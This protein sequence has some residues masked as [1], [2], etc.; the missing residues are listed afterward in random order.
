MVL[1][2]VI[3]CTYKL[4][5]HNPQ[6]EVNAVYLIPFSDA[7]HSLAHLD[8]DIPSEWLM[9]MKFSFAMTQ[10]VHV[11]DNDKYTV[12]SFFSITADAFLVRALRF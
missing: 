9:A 11:G 1:A 12:L 7:L 10:Y 2:T 4:D 5:I 3:F 6:D 8:L